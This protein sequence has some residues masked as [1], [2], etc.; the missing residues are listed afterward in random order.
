[1]D[2]VRLSGDCLEMRS[3]VEDKEDVH[4]RD[5]LPFDTALC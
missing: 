4:V 2:G 1:M 3:F 5:L